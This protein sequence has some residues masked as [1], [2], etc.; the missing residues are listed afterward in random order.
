MLQALEHPYLSPLHEPD[1]EPTCPE[2][3]NVDVDV[4]NASP[5]KIKGS[6]GLGLC[7]TLT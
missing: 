4:T 5:G 6:L 7:H 1:D 3:I 2:P